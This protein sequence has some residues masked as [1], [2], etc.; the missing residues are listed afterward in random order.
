MKE[1]RNWGSQ[2]IRAK[3]STAIRPSNLSLKA[4]N[5]AFFKGRVCLELTT[6]KNCLIRRK[7]GWAIPR[8]EIGYASYSKGTVP[9]DAI[10]I[11]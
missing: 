6:A 2:Q 7:V 9:Q 4:F 3:L 5:V 8:T 10:G 11:K 1:G